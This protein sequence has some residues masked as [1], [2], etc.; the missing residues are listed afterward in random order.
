MSNLPRLAR[1]A[2]TSRHIL[3]PG[4]VAE[5]PERPGKAGG[6]SP[7]LAMLSATDGLISDHNPEIVVH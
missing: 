3:A 2:D 4:R 7:L 1:P 5:N 6:T